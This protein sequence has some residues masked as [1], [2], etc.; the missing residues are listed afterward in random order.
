MSLN[1]VVN[2][3]IDAKVASIKTLYNAPFTDIVTGEDG[4]IQPAFTIQTTVMGRSIGSRVNQYRTIVDSAA[5][6]VPIFTVPDGYFETFS[7][8]GVQPSINCSAQLWVSN[9]AVTFYVL[10]SQAITGLVALTIRIYLCPP[11]WTVYG[12]VTAGIASFITATFQYMAGGLGTNIQ[13]TG[14]MVAGVPQLVYTVPAGRRV[15]FSTL[16]LA[17]SGGSLNYGAAT[18]AP[19]STRSIVRDINGVDWLTRN[20]TL[21]SVPASGNLSQLDILSEGE[22]IYVVTANNSPAFIVFGLI[23]SYPIE[24]MP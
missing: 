19:G 5:G 14:N 2:P 24:S 7:Y 17:V 4:K 18:T 21:S 20:Q 8:V 10:S 23:Q 15:V 11:G 13:W 12:R 3:N 22:Q 9:D 6:Y 1:E 16:G